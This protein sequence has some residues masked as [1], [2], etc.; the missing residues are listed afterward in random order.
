MLIAPDIEMRRATVDD[1]QALAEAQVRNKEHLRSTEPH[2]EAEFYTAEG[3]VERITG[4]G[5]DTWLLVDRAAD[6][7]VVGRLMLNGIVMGPLC[8]ASLG[9]WVDGGYAGRGLTTA[10]VEEIIRIC[11]DEIGLHRIEAGTLTDNFASQRVLTKCGFERYGLSAK[12]L[13]INGAWRDHIR[14]ER[15]LHDDP[16]PHVPK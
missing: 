5:S 16:P 13:H 1:A 4:A 14:F 7:I 9:Y 3:Q 10:A 2:R 8:G 6:G 12:Y 15:L 11:R